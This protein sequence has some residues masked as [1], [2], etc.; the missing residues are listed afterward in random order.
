MNKVIPILFLDDKEVHRDYEIVLDKAGQHIEVLVLA[1]LGKNGWAFSNLT[2]HHKAANT[3]SRTI[4][5]A[6]L[7]GNG[8]FKLGGVIRVDPGCNGVKAELKER[9]LLLSDQAK[10]EATPSMEVLTNEVK[11]SHGASVSRLSDEELFYLRSR[12]IDEQEATK[13][14]TSGFIEEVI[15]KLN[16]Q[17]RLKARLKLDTLLSSL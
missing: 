7:T 12:G 1:L 15:G 9:A 10:V 3:S 2:I 5:R 4:G 13:L 8:F 17:Q 6:V 14:L 16:K 11:V